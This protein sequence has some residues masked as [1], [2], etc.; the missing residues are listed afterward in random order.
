MTLGKEPKTGFR[1]PHSSCRIPK[2]LPDSPTTSLPDLPPRP[3]PPLFDPLRPSP[4]IPAPPRPSPPLPAPPHPSPPLHTSPRSSP[5]LAAPPPS[6]GFYVDCE[7]FQSGVE[8]VDEVIDE[9][10]P[11]EAVSRR[12]TIKTYITLFQPEDE[13]KIDEFGVAKVSAFLKNFFVKSHLI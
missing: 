3:S 5:P 7:R 2:T 9:R 4:P 8:A 1:P 12:K 10:A 13:K 11:T 6:P